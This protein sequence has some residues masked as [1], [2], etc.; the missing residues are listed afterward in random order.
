MLLDEL[1]Y[2]RVKLAVEAARASLDRM[3]LFL[4]TPQRQASTFAEH[5]AIVAALA[6]HD[7]AAAARAMEHHLDVVMSELVEFAASHPEAVETG[8][9]RT[10]AA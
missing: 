8:I 10:I 7:P 2:E 4:C 6:A 3:R 5:Q 1:G 9:G